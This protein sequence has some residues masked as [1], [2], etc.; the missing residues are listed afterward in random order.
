M[1]QTCRRGLFRSASRRAAVSSL[2]KATPVTSRMEKTAIYEQVLDIDE[3][4]LNSVPSLINAGFATLALDI[5]RYAREALC[6]FQKAETLGDTRYTDEIECG[7]RQARSILDGGE[8]TRICEY[9]F[10]I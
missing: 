7:K 9:A 4:L 8:A 1:F 6:F 3:K 5:R 2:A 10:R